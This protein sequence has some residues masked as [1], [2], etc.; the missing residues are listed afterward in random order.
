MQEYGFSL[1][2]ILPHKNRT[3][4]SVFIRENIYTGKYRSVKTGILAYFI[5][6][7]QFY[8]SIL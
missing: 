6:C 7:F 2:G 1:T 4:D 3:Y 5:Q 8:I